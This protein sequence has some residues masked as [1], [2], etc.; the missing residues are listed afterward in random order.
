[1]TIHR[2][3]NQEIT[4]TDSVCPEKEV[5]VDDFIDATIK[6]LEEYIKNSKERLIKTSNNRYT[7]HS[8]VNFD[9][10]TQKSQGD[11]IGLVWSMSYQTLLVIQCQI[12]F[13]FSYILDIWFVNTFCR[14]KQLN[15]Q[16]VLCLTI[17]YS[18]S[19]S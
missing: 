2:V 3:Y 17:Q 13:F 15:I 16:T 18:K 6:R 14:Y 8:I 12:L 9:K 11:L 10:N 1:M 7:N 4:I 5:E 19:Q